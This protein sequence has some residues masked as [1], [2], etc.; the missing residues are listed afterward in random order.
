MGRPFIEVLLCS[1]LISLPGLA[2]S[3]NNA[4]S[5]PR[6][7]VEAQKILA[8]AWRGSQLMGINVHGGDGSRVGSIQDIVGDVKGQ[9]LYVILS[10]GGVLGIGNRLIP[11][12]WEMVAPGE[13]PGTLRVQLSKS[14]LEQAPNFD[15]NNWPDFSQSEWRAKTKDYYENFRMK[16]RKKTE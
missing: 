4:K 10:V 7:P 6:E 12:P 3:E 8:G 5:V 15:H 11:L 1:L 14:D 2:W 16:I 13:A 9:V